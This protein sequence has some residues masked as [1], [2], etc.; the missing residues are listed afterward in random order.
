MSEGNGVTE[1]E[2]A[3]EEQRELSPD[4]FNL[5]RIPVRF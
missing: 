3:D 4:V 2:L 5:I 1:D